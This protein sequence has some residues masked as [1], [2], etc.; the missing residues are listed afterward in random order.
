MAVAPLRLAMAYL[1]IGL[2]PL[3]FAVRGVNETHE[4]GP[5]SISH[6]AGASYIA[7]IR[8]SPLAPLLVAASDNP[9]DG[10][11]SSA[12]LFEDGRELRP[13]HAVH[14]GISAVGKGR[15][16]H[17]T[18]A[19]YLSA[20]DNSD[21]RTNGRVYRLETVARLPMTVAFAWA[22]TLVLAALLSLP[23][24]PLGQGRWLPYV[25]P[26]VLAMPSVVAIAVM[27]TAGPGAARFWALASWIA[28]GFAAAL[29]AGVVISRVSAPEFGGGVAAVG[30]AL[31]AAWDSVGS[32]A[33]S[34]EQRTFEHPGWRGYV[35]RGGCLAVAAGIFVAMLTIAWPEWILERAY[36]G[37]GLVILAAA[38]ALW[39]A[40]A[41]RGWLAM[42]FG[43]AVTLG[44]FGL[45]LAALWQDVTIHE[46]AIGGLL[47]FSDAQGYYLEAN[48]LLD[49]QP[50]EWSARRPLFTSFLAVLLA[51]TGS[52]YVALA[53]MVALNAVATFLLAREVRRSFGPAAA[54]VTALILFA[55]YRRDGGTG[56]VLSE[57]L[58]LLL[59]TAAFT[60][61]LRG[62]RLQDL[63][64]YA[65]GA[66]VLS[67][68]LMARAGAFFVLPALVAVALVSVRHGG[69]R[70]R[71]NMTSALATVGAIGIA[72]AAVLLW[73][74]TVSDPSAS[75]TAF[76]NYSQSLYGLVVGGKGWTQVH[77]DH[78]NA[79]EGAE[80][81]ALAYA[82]FRA[83][84]SGLI[85]GLTKMAR[86]YIWPNE[87][88]HA[89]AFITDASRTGLLQRICYMLAL[90]GLGACVWRWRDPVYSLLLAAA[91]GHL[92]SIPF[93]PPIDAGLRVYA[94]TVP[95]VAL[96]VAAGIAVPGRLLLGLRRNAGTGTAPIAGHA[97][98]RLS[99]TSALILIAVV[100]GMSWT[101]YAA[102]EPTTLTR[103]SCPDGNEAL[104]VRI[105]DDAVLRIHDNRTPRAISPTTVRQSE[106]QRSL[107]AVELRAEASNLRAGMSLVFT[108]DLLDGRQVW[109]AGETRQLR[110]GSGPLQICGHYAA[111][112]M[113]RRYGLIYVDDVSAAEIPLSR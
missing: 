47:P 54:T 90:V 100:M 57:N 49:G 71:L 59:G 103:P 79:K 3:A 20:S 76:S 93:V 64:S 109:L 77:I 101:L 66:A 14:A 83:R 45:P 42:L 27:A 32:L 106:V 75:N 29:C 19:V 25:R 7:P 89:F 72:G 40:H 65:S 82:A 55:F 102:G 41:G 51:V 4:I 21:P 15:F 28:V 61:L 12:R 94:A 95:I 16:S 10:R 107:H 8:Q 63:R 74:K 46:N 48:R 81:Y 33:T 91:A 22:L 39:L 96:I 111:D 17:W 80:I 1:V 78:P 86:A 99:E 43:L 73:G 113:A 87:P 44:L 53:V 84:P 30:P 60:A 105:D 37:G 2:A 97:T 18:T 69:R 56:V 108:Y 13:A 68:A 70:R 23:F 31:R 92:A 9:S 50:L 112:E 11:R 38:A 24:Q 62:V 34:L 5:A 85:E 6:V 110:A 88:Y 58:G 36:G 26:M 67:A 52:L 35:A 104:L 98:T